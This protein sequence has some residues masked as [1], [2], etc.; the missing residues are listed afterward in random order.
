MA[1]PYTAAAVTATRKVVLKHMEWRGAVGASASFALDKH[2]AAVRAD[3]RAKYEPIIEKLEEALIILDGGLA[4][5]EQVV[6][7]ARR[8]AEE[9]TGD[10]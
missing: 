6:E 8:D 3:E 5:A 1:N 2:E 9:V 4:A 10:G 7:A